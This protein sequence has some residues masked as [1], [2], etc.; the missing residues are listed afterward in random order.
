[1]VIIIMLGTKIVRGFVRIVRIYRV[2]LADGWEYRNRSRNGYTT[3]KAQKVI[4]SYLGKIQV[5]ISDGRALKS[6]Q[7]LF[8]LLK[9]YKRLT[10]DGQYGGWYIYIYI[11][12]FYVSAYSHLYVIHMNNKYAISKRRHV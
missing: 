7:L 6:F 5:Q 10:L 3:E 4:S 9:M 1:M 11:Y 8:P 12:L 2:S